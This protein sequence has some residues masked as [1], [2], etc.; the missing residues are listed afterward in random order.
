MKLRATLHS[1]PVM[2]VDFFH[3][4]VNSYGICI[5]F[6]G[7]LKVCQIDEFENVQWPQKE[8]HVVE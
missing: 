7:K 5:D 8:S 1:K 2:I 3:D 4:E 6:E